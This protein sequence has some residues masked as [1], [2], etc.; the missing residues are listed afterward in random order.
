MIVGVIG[1]GKSNVL[2][3]FIAQLALCEDALIFVVDLKGGRMARPWLMPWLEDPD[4]VRRPVIDWLATTRKEADLM[5]DTLL[6]AGDTR[7]AKG[8]GGE[9]ITPRRDMPQVVI[10]F[11]ETAVAT[12]HGRKDDEVSSRAL[13]VKV[14]RLAETYRSEAFVPV[15]SAIRGDVETLGLTAIKAQALARIGL[16]VS[17]SGDGDSVFPDNH[18]AAKALANIQDD[19]AGLF[20]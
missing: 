6:A 20:C 18:A 10:L 9:K 8:S 13:A 14:A 2:N 3:V 7:A 5:L 15:V 19:G 4:G 16:R 1:S 12:G 11:D 17:Q